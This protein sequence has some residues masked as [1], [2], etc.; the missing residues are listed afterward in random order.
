MTYSPL[1]AK[2]FD[3]QWDSTHTYPFFE[4]ERGDRLYAYGH[5]RD[6]EFAA[7]ATRFGIEIGEL[8]PEDAEC[9][10]EDITHHWAVVTDPEEQSF[11]WCDIT[12][13]TPGAFPV[14]VLE[15]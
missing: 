1:T 5:D 15:R 9:T 10:T 2:D 14:S 4:D 7:E 12:E 6:A 11:T 3:T 8:D 13:N